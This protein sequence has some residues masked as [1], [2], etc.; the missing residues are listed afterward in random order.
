MNDENIVNILIDLEKNGLKM[1]DLFILK[2]K[3]LD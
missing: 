2:M 3:L 1:Q